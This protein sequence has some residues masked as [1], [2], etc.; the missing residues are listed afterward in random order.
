M[1]T[2]RE[3]IELEV[4]QA[5]K[6]QDKVEL[7]TLRMLLNAIKNEQ[8]RIGKEV[9]DSTFVKLVQSGIKQRRDSIEQYEKGGRQD[10]ADRERREAEVLGR[11]LPEQADEG[12]IRAAIREFVEDQSLAGP[13]SMGQVMQAM[14]A[15][16]GASADGATI[17]RIAR[18][19]L[20]EKS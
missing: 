8:I 15:R 11:Y 10:L 14:I 20:F 18:E 12:E 4:R 17:N 19:I 6:A 1:N 3:R 16:F 13:Q 5:L 7:S 2:P 9:D